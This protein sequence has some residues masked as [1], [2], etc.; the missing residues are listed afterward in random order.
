MNSSAKEAVD[1]PDSS[2][3]H[4]SPDKSIEKRPI[5]ERATLMKGL[6]MDNESR[7]PKKRYFIFKNSSKHEISIYEY[8]MICEL[9][10]KRL[11]RDDFD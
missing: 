3:S 9:N 2:S 7:G 8:E 6:Y 5:G 1:V 11:F 10:F 4:T